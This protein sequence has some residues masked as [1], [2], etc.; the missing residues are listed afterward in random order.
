MLVKILC[1]LSGMIIMWLLN[2]F[3]GIGHSIT[4]LKETQRNCALLFTTS[5]QGFHEILQ[6]KY[7]AMVEAK[8][9][10]QNIISQKYIDQL[11]VDN[12]KKSIMRNYA[13]VFPISYRHI[14]EYT[15]WEE[16]EDYVNKM[17]RDIKESK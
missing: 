10:E 6:L 3:L 13:G 2:Y 9:T 11:N 7:L 14:M 5:E 4:L 1:F 8:R 15:T 12:M 17:V 16:L